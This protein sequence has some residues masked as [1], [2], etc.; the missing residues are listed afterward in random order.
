MENCGSPPEMHCGIACSIG[1]INVFFFEAVRICMGFVY[2]VLGGWF[3]NFQISSSQNRSRSISR[4][5]NIYLR[6]ISH[7]VIDQEAPCDPSYT[8]VRSYVRFSSRTQTL[9]CL[10]LSPHRH[11][12]ELFFSMPPY[13][14]WRE[15]VYSSSFPTSIV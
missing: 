15:E 1:F 11:S 12:E 6:R 8:L 13:Y 2:F 4:S 14:P 3:S 7:H 5:Q 10:R 9:K